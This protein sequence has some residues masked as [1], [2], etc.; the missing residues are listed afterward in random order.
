MMY[1]VMWMNLTT[2]ICGPLDGFLNEENAKDL[3]KEK[4]SVA[5]GYAYWIAYSGGLEPQ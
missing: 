4:T 5:D 3:I 2:G 1:V